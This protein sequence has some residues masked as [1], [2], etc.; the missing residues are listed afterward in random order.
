MEINILKD[1][2]AGVPVLMAGAGETGRAGKKGTIFFFH[3]LG[4]SK[5]ANEKELRSLAEAGFLA[6]GADNY[7]HGQRRFRDFEKVMA[8]DN[9]DRESVFV[10]AV[11]KTAGALPA[12]ID[13]L[14]ARRGT[15]GGGIGV[16]G[17]SMGGYIAYEAVLA[18]RRI[19]A[20]V[21]IIGS[22]EW[23]AAAEKCPARRPERFYPAAVLSQTAG[24]DTVVPPDAA[25]RLHER[26][27]G[28]YAKEPGRQSYI[29]YPES[30]HF[31]RPEDWDALWKR[32][33]EWFL[34][35]L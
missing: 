5:E 31:M 17:I 4:V 25:R 11:R 8:E 10:D 28:Y 22:P 27:A 20:A 13:D 14:A 1:K 2:L 18:D 30:E 7:G 12:M 21:P 32:T 3:G 34:R 33:V 26:L 6:V 23:K 24:R 15:G 16:A 35:F 29:E 9:P 19:K